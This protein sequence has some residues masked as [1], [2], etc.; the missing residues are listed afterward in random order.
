MS[1]NLKTY[2]ARAVEQLVQKVSEL[3]LSGGPG[4]VCVFQAPTGSGKTVMTAKFIEELIREL[5]EEDICFLWVS[6]GKGELHIQSKNRL[7]EVFKGSPRVSLIE[8]E[9]TGGRERIVRNEVV[10]ANWEKIRNRDNKTGDWTNISMREGEITNFREVLLKTR[11]QRKLIL[12]IDES[13]INAATERANELREIISADVV[14]EMSATPRLMPTLLD[15]TRGA[16]GY[17]RVE[18]NDVIEE[19]MIKKEVVINENIEE[20]SSSETDSQNTVLESAYRKRI[21]LEKAYRAIGSH[22]KPL[23]LIQIPVAEAGDIKIEAVREFLSTK[24]ITEDNQ[25]LAIWLS[26]QK[27][28]TIKEIA[29]NESPIEFLVFKQAIDT[30][31]DCPRAQ[32]LVK[33]REIKS[34]VFEIQTVGRILRMPEQKH[35]SD[36]S[37]NKAYVFTN[38]ESFDV[39]NEDYNPNIIN[40]LRAKRIEKYK[41]LKITSYYKSR[42]DYG[43]ITSSFASSFE[44]KVNNYF[45]ISGRMKGNEIKKILEKRGILLDLRQYRQKI[46]SNT[47][48]KANSFDDMQGKVRAKDYVRLVLAANDLQALFEQIIRENLGPFT[49]INRSIPPVKSSI[50][51]WFRKYLSSDEWDNEVVL[52]QQIFVLEKNRVHFVKALAEAIDAYKYVRDEEIR[53][54]IEEGEQWY[55]F[56]L[57]KELFFNKHQDERVESKLYA[58]RPSYLSVSRSRPE[59]EFESFLDEQKSIDWWW[60]N[61]ERKKEYFGIKY[62][63]ASNIHTFY[64]DYLVRLKDGRIGFFEVKDSAD[65]D[66]RTITKAKA[67]SLQNWILKQKRKDLFGGIVVE[68]NK[69]WYI[70]FKKSYLWEKS[71]RGDWSDWERLEL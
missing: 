7:E 55:E 22:I 64:P 5:P 44:E 15:V 67:E 52:I 65:R 9:F 68:R 47:T 71:E 25:K 63:Y 1:I 50:Y 36:E 32:I 58:Y 56:D 8:G 31:W 33:F 62:E 45:G 23:V 39:K 2:Q 21:D 38:L 54:R 11:E 57:S 61:G 34:E 70:N 13:H 20:V 4:E 28:E 46:I 19:G 3:L 12:I 37:L 35:Y 17:I 48:I 16:A 49:N 6:I 53:K 43:D 40:H 27:S 30:G 29:L 24:G 14:V 10:I 18:P 60:K 66:G 41:P 59:R 69:N 26:E 42:A 51:S